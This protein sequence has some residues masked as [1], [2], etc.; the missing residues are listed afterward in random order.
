M[1]IKVTTFTV[2]Q[3]LY[4][5]KQRIMSRAQGINTVTPVSL[6]QATLPSAI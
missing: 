4:Y 5:T 1:N 2:T 6:E 3:K